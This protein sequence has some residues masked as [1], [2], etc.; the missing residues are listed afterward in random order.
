[1]QKLKEL[2]SGVEEATKL[3]GYIRSIQNRVSDEDFKSRLNIV[4]EF[5]NRIVEPK[6]RGNF[7][8]AIRDLM[9]KAIKE[10]EKQEETKN[11]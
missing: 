4:K 5:T 10:Q 8:Q 11:Q 7:Q 6:Y 1:M 3:E 9:Q 2:R